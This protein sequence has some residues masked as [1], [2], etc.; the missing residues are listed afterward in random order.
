MKYRSKPVEAI[1]RTQD[2]KQEIDA[3][4]EDAE[5]V[6][7]Y[8]KTASS[9]AVE[10]LSGTVLAAVGDWIVRIGTEAICLSDAEFK[11]NFE[12]NE[13]E[14][15][16]ANRIQGI[17]ETGKP[18]TDQD[19]QQLIKAIKPYQPTPPPQGDDTDT[20]QG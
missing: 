2:N 15:T 12:P 14:P 8:Q 13:S 16:P 17:K 5:N 7:V 19:I 6:M 20:L 18:L 11:A 10:T 9:L 4:F 3:M 1:Q